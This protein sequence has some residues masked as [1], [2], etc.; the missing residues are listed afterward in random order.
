MKGG[1][2]AGRGVG[3]LTESPIRGQ[4]DHDLR[5]ESYINEALRRK[6]IA[7]V[8][9]SK[10]SNKDSHRVAT[11]LKAKGYRIIPVNPTADS[12]MGE[13]CYRNL[14]EIPHE[15]QRVIDVVDVFR[16]SSDLP[17]IT[18]Q[19]LK[20]REAAGRPDFLWTQL[21][22][23]DLVAAERAAKSGLKVIMNR[24]MMVEHGR[25]MG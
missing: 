24:C 13:K 5:L 22:I 8:G 20:M 19:L 15:L 17:Y 18:G 16:P 11:Y 10:D 21:G 4:F 9:L 2:G 3:A 12:I 23:E 1:S 25:R 6:T 7:V 14:L